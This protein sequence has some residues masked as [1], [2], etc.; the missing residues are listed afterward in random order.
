MANG[1][2]LTEQRNLW[3]KWTACCNVVHAIRWNC[4]NFT[5]LALNGVSMARSYCIVH[6]AESE[7]FMGS[8]VT[9][10]A[11]NMCSIYTQIKSNQ[12]Y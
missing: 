2:K 7:P 10:K 1:I 12:I 8:Y 4:W 11:D 3:A 6:T 5:Y 9:K